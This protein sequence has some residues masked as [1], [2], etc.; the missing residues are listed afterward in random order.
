MS[1]LLLGFVVSAALLVADDSA[2]DAQKQRLSKLQAFVGQWRGVGQPQRSSNKDSWTEDAD[3]AWSFAGDGPVLA[4]KLPKGRYF[5]QLRLSASAADGL[6]QLTATPTAGGEPLTYTGRLDEQQQLVL[7]PDKPREGLPHQLSFRF[8]ANGDR[9]LLLMEKQAAASGQ[10]TRLAEV[11]YTRQG[12]GFGKNL[13]QREC[14]VTGGLGTIEVTHNGQTYHVC[15]TG[16]R[17]YFNENPEKVL[18]EYKAKKK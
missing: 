18:A 11:G 3:W 16:C 8:T 1:R 5:S 10:F 6:Y 7:S 14:V 9:L 15:C 17:D 12:S 2:P 13:T 4:A